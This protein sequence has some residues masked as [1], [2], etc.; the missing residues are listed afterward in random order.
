MKLKSIRALGFKSF[1]DKVDLEFKTS[2]TAIVGPNGSG[3]SNIVDAVRWVLGEQSVKSLRGSGSMSDVIF[4]GSETRPP[5]K[6]AEVSLTFDNTEHYLNTD[7]VDVEVKRI[8]YYTGENEYFINNA[9]VRLKDITNLFLDSGI[10]NDSFNIISQGNIESI[11]N[12]KPQDRRVI[13]ES[14]AG[15]LKYKTRKQESL[16]KLEKTK[17]NIEKVDLVINEL[18]ENVTSLKEQSEL[19]KK[20]VGYKDELEDLEI[21][22]TTYDITA[23]NKE[24]E[25]ISKEI[26]ELEAEKEQLE[27]KN[28][29]DTSAIEKLKV[30]LMHLEEE[31]NAKNS[32]F[33]R[34][35][36][37]LSKLNSQKTLFL[38]RQ[39]YEVDEE[40]LNESYLKLKETELSLQKN[41]EFTLK[42][43]M[44]LESKLKSMQQEASSREEEMSLFLVKYNHLKAEL[45]EKRKKIFAVQNQ[46]EI[47]SSNLENDVTLPYAVKNVLNNPR[48]TGIHN[49]IGKVIETKNEYTTALDVALSSSANF[50][51]TDDETAAKKAISY[52]KEN[53]LGRAT[54]FPLNIIKPR[55]LPESIRRNAE[56]IKGFIGVLSDLVS[57]DKIYDNIIKNQL[58]TIIVA[59]DL[60]ACN[61]IGAALE[62]KYRVVS[63]EGDILHTGGSLTGGSLKKQNSSFK[64]KQELDAKKEELDRTQKLLT[65]LEQKLQEYETQKSEKETQAQEIAK[66][67][68]IT[69]ELIYRK[70]ITLKENESELEIITSRLEGAEQVKENKVESAYITLLE[71]IK[72]SELEKETVERSLDTLKAQ[73]SDLSSEIATMEQSSREKNGAYRKV[74]QALKEKEINLSK[75][76][77]KMDY[78]LSLLS[79]TYELTYEKAKREYVLEIEPE[80]ARA[81][82]TYLRKEMN[83]LG[84]VNIGSIA[85]YERVSTRYNFLLE[86]KTDLEVS[87]K[88]LMSVIEEMDEIMVEKLKDA[89]EKIE[90]EFSNVFKK[91][92][93]GGNGMLRLT[94]PDN[95]LETGIEIVAE[96]PG[97]KLNSIALLS[98][99]EKTLTAISLLFAILNV[100]PVPFCILD[101]VEAALDEANVDTF[102]HYLQSRQDKSEFILITH[103]KRTMEYA[104]TLYGITMQEQGVSKVVSVRLES[105]EEY[106]Q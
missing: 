99:G 106:G 61:K 11:I 51:I 17:D 39:D 1:A 20:Y 91:M 26:K 7:L 28:S 55:E 49:T 79:E 81:K 48:L 32:E 77:T 92:F 59:E 65:S 57:Y 10:G 52:L 31:I 94:D 73:K 56:S 9:K 84:D 2:I 68:S 25:R 4:S 13:L 43:K 105:K 78:L 97:K 30:D 53:K 93:K 33:I 41:H 21:A 71:Q 87:S 18:E 98:G 50:I 45:E 8:L 29:T 60:D 89:F 66:N 96:P 104:G 35:N 16:R 3:K 67:I 70:N 100:Y 86:Q 82:V 63:L 37:E 24:Y 76:D 88:E 90:K 95:I 19:A 34:I 54:F 40:R 44:D 62:Y 27:F 5:F 72:E 103:K 58:G 102:G 80:L 85:E 36:E 46:I 101:E 14:A 69:A 75:Y 64:M 15:V 74:E 47:L 38:E 23:L 83:A 12:A 22:L 42:E 6:R